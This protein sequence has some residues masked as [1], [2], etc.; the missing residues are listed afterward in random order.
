MIDQELE[1]LI[2]TWE[3]IQGELGPTPNMQLII[4]TT[5]VKLYELRIWKGQSR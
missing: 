2:K 4:R 1:K 5:L 3:K